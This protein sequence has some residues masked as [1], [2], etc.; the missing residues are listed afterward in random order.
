MLGNLFLAPVVITS[1]THQP[2]GSPTAYPVHSNAMPQQFAPVAQQGMPMPYGAPAPYPPMNAPYSPP[3][4]PP[5]PGSSPYPPQGAPYQGAGYPP[6]VTPY[7]QGMMNPPSYND[8]VNNESF[9]KQAAY[10]PNF[11]G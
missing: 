10:N 4:Y 7:Q 11:S 9:Q 3:M 1:Q 8:A 6:Q 2:V 5:A